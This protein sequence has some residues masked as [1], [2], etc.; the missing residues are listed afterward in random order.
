[1]KATI[2]LLFFACTLQAQTFK[3]TAELFSTLK[4]NK[5]SE[6]VNMGCSPKSI[7]VNKKRLII[8]DDTI[9]L[10]RYVGAHQGRDSTGKPYAAFVFI[11]RDK[12]EICHVVI[13]KS[14]A[15]VEIQVRKLNQR[16]L[17]K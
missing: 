1:M 15:I 12:G 4:N 17:Y 8:R 14:D 3:S 2:L 10:T 16:T 6:Y 13:V 11:A 9:Q 5:W 7:H